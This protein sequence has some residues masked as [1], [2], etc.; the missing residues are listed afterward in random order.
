M[1]K[2][3]V[4]FSRVLPPPGDVERAIRDTISEVVSSGYYINGPRNERFRS[5]FAEFVGVSNVVTVGN[6]TD[7]L[8]VAL[9]ALGVG[10]GDMVITVANAGGYASTA[11][12]AVG[13]TAVYVEIDES[14]LLIDVD[15]LKELVGRMPSKP[16]AIIV[17]HLYGV[18]AKIEEL[19]LFCSGYGILL[20][21]D[22]AQAIGVRPG[23]QHVGSFG[24]VG[25]FSF[26][27]TKNLG[28]MGDSGAI[29]TNDVDIAKRARMIAQYGWG[30]DRYVSLVSGGLNSR[31][32]EVQAGVLTVLLPYVEERNQRRTEI[33]NIYCDVSTQLKFPHRGELDYNG[34][35]AVLVPPSRQAALEVMER[36]G[37]EV[38]IHYPV[39]DF[40]QPGFGGDAESYPVTS[41]ACDA[42]LSLPVFPSLS[43]E[44]IDLVCQALKTIQQEAL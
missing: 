11:I 8:I 15:Q 41:A 14:N 38:S 35:L 20:V 9:K 12:N 2:I 18:G 32:D 43:D 42:V 27:P 3:S 25:T 24:D 17:T 33:F 29:V 1:E 21:E 36:F 39:P 4:P 40:R 28:G 34:H 22:C 37:I 23:G 31:M 30:Q 19:S 26:Y 6:G 7:A 5:E 10:V 13:A 16:R 44:E